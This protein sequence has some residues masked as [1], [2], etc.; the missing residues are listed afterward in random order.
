MTSSRKVECS[1]EHVRSSLVSD[2]VLRPEH[3][4][5][6]RCEWLVPVDSGQTLDISTIY[7]YI[8]ISLS[9]SV[10]VQIFF[11]RHLKTVALILYQINIELQCDPIDST[12]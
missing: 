12:E 3:G 2:H 7:I 1:G 11:I 10:L 9:L 5:L 8:C 4:L 6:K